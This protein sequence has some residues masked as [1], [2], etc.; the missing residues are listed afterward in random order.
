MLIIGASIYAAYLYVP[1]AYGA[2][3]VKEMMQHYVDVGSAQ[4]KPPAWAA[5]QIVKNFN[6]YGVPPNAV[7]SNAKRDNRIEVRIQYVKAVEF[8]GYTYNYEFDHTARS[9]ALLDFSK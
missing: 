1:V 2:H 4:G 8:P 7:I 6:E 3:N 5:E 9:T